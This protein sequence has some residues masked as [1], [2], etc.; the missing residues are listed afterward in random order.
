MISFLFL[1][2]KIVLY[3]LVVLIFI[4]LLFKTNLYSQTLWGI[5]MQDSKLPMSWQVSDGLYSKEVIEEGDF[6]GIQ[7]I[8]T[9][10]FVF[11]ISSPEVENLSNVYEYLVN[12]F[13]EENFNKDYISPN[14]KNKGN[15]KK[16]EASVNDGRSYVFREWKK[17]QLIIRLFWNQ[18]RFWVEVINRSFQK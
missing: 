4:F 11:Y 15:E 3:L 6:D 12:Q 14:L 1:L 8:P 18:F 7:F 10:G 13:E 17:N 9:V 2:K 16:L 5:D